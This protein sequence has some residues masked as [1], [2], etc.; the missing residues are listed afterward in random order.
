M[1]L[2]LLGLGCSSP[3]KGAA[4]LAMTL[5]VMPRRCRA[6]SGRGV[7]HAGQ[8]GPASS[9]APCIGSGAGRQGSLSACRR[10]GAPGLLEKR[11]RQQLRSA[12]LEA[13]GSTIAGVATVWYACVSLAVMQRQH[14]QVGLAGTHWEA[15]RER[16]HMRPR[17]TPPPGIPP[18]AGASIQLPHDPCP[19]PA[20]HRARGHGS[21]NRG[22][23]Q[24]LRLRAQPLL[25]DH[26]LQLFCTTAHGHLRESSAHRGRHDAPS[27]RPQRGGEGGP[28][29]GP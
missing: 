27:G 23:R 12:R 29:P 9:C 1:L 19:L 26:I 13:A 14:D 28:H 18:L 15:R 21:L 10:S 2:L 16:H 17:Q 6:A 8:L 4:G 3:E 11:E 5:G 24:L 7:L 22:P 20:R 25:P